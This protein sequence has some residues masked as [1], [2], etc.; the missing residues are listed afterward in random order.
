M[1]RR[2]FLQTTAAALLVPTWRMEKRITSFDLRAFCEKNVDLWW[3]YGPKYDCTKPITQLTADFPWRYATDRRI[4]VRV[5]EVEI[6]PHDPHGKEPPCYNLPWKHGE[7]AGWRVWPAKNHLLAS[8]T[9]CPHCKGEGWVIKHG[10]YDHR[11]AHCDDGE[12]IFPSIQPIGGTFID[13]EYDALIRQQLGDNCE[14][15]L[16]QYSWPSKPSPTTIIEFRF[17]GGEGLLC[18]LESKVARERLVKV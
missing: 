17:E 15:R 3:A 2:S 5:P 7:G 13:C 6:I 9:M 11:C 4:C 14:W 16:H 10:V 18:C 12:G 8:G 1:N